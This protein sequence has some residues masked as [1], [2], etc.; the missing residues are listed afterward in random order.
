MAEAKQVN[1]YTVVMLCVIIGVAMGCRT[2]PR[3]MKKISRHFC[4][5]GAKMGLNLVRCTRADEIKRQLVAVVIRFL[6]K[7]KYPPPR[8]NPGY[9]YVRNIVMCKITE[10]SLF[11]VAC[12]VVVC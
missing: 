9:A 2:P 4:W 1:S 6:V 7:K 12:L 10:L 3:A 8:E 11:C 5:N